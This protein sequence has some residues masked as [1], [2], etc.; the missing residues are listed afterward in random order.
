MVPF[1]LMQSKEIFQASANLLETCLE[2]EYK[3]II[4]GNDID[5][6]K[7]LLRIHEDCKRHRE[8]LKTTLQPQKYK[9]TAKWTCPTDLPW[10]TCVKKKKKMSMIKLEWSSCRRTFFFGV[11]WNRSNIKGGILIKNQAKFKNW[12]QCKPFFHG[13]MIYIYI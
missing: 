1:R 8:L 3:H 4:W 11:K 2:T 7:C 5:L 13:L 9:E 6:W 10:G 12:K